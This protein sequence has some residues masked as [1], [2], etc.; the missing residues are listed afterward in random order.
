MKGHQNVAIPS[1]PRASRCFGCR[2]IDPG[3]AWLVESHCGA[4]SDCNRHTW[5]AGGKAYQP[6][7]VERIILKHYDH[8]LQTRPI[9]VTASRTGTTQIIAVVFQEHIGIGDG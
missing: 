7:V 6:M 9:F 5:S 1:L 3:S 4:L 2:H 8:W